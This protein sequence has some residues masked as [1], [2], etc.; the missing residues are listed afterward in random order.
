MNVAVCLVWSVGVCFMSTTQLV[1]RV[2]V[3]RTQVS[4]R[5]GCLR[6]LSSCCC[7][8]LLLTR[9]LS[10][11]VREDVGKYCCW[12]SAGSCALG[13]LSLKP[14][15]VVLVT[16]TSVV[17]RRKTTGHT[18][19]ALW[20]H[21]CAPLVLRRAVR[22]VQSVGSLGQS[23]VSYLV[24]PASSHMLVSKIKPCMSKYKHLYCETANGSLNQLSFIRLY[25]TTWIPVVILELIHAKS[26][27]FWKGCIY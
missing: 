14:V 16:T 5:S 3:W 7:C 19:A 8:G 22:T 10:P 20:G 11:E 25:I 26:P 23:V 6:W 2:S 13:L 12:L 9:L 27:D 4:L 21:V 18:R 17:G 15:V 24:D 1:R